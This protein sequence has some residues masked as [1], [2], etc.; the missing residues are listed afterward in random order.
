MTENTQTEEKSDVNLDNSKEK[1]NS[2]DSSTETTDTNSTD[3][4]SEQNKNQTET[5]KDSENLADHPR[6]KER[7]NDWTKRFNE[8]ETRHTQEI[9]TIRKDIETRFEKKREDLADADVPEWFGGDAKAWAQYK[10]HED[11]RLTQAENNAIKRLEEKAEKQQKAIDEA[12]GYFNDEVKAL[13]S[14]KELNPEGKV[15]RNKLLKFTM[16]NDL[17]D[18]KGRWNYKAAF[19]LMKAG[20]TNA[21]NNSTEEKK[22]IA[23]ATTSEKTAETKA[24]NVKTSADFKGKSWGSL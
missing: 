13:E 22:K 24:S 14:D 5:K 7:E 18:S 9:E 10:A 3:E 8:Q 12:T 15:D 11:A 1:D 16:D 4:S 23:A 21:K 20:V 17:V 2:A 19:K 6:W